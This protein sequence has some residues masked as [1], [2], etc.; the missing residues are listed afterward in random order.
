MAETAWGR[1]GV[2]KATYYRRLKSAK[3]QTVDDAPT[4]RTTWLDKPISPDLTIRVPVIDTAKS[5]VF[6]EQRKALE[7]A[8]VRLI[9]LEDEVARLKRLL[10][11]RGRPVE[12]VVRAVGPG[13]LSQSEVGKSLLTMKQAREMKHEAM[14]K[15]R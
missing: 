5:D 6:I 15:V 7:A 3:P 10:A 9:E 1:E 11:E 2:S 8:Q 13:L 14:L 4:D 12:T